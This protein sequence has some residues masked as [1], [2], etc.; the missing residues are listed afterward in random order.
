M[1]FLSASV[2]LCDQIFCI[3]ITPLRLL[4]LSFRLDS[5]NRGVQAVPY[6]QYANDASS[7]FYHDIGNKCAYSLAVIR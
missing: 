6:C 7:L 1:Y 2:S 4:Y 3:R 5:C